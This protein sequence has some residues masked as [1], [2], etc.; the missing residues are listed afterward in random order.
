[1]DLLQDGLHGLQHHNMDT[2]DAFGLHSSILSIFE[3][4]PNG[5]VKIFP[6]LINNTVYFNI[7]NYIVPKTVNHN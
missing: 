4:S 6:L 5:L 2:G 1:M 3:G 7:I